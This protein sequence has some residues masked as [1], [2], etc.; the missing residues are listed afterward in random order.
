MH[1]GEGA[2]NAPFYRRE[3]VKV[4]WDGGSDLSAWFGSYGQGGGEVGEWRRD[5]AENGDGEKKKDGSDQV[6]C[7]SRLG[8]SRVCFRVVPK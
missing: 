8:G 4:A 6:N 5:P 1:R 3:W 2:H 7:L